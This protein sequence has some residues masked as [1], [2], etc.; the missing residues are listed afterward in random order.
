MSGMG[1][2]ANKI[3]VV[4]L[5]AAL[6]RDQPF[7]RERQVVNNEDLPALKRPKSRYSSFL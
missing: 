5:H 1:N 6:R 3:S 4:I 2:V 7:A